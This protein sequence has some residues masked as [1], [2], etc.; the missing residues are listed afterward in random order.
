M[1]PATQASPFEFMDRNRRGRSCT[2]NPQLHVHIERTTT[3]KTRG[4]PS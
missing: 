4:R 2:N 3:G 1:T